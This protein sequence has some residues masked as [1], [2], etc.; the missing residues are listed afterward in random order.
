MILTAYALPEAQGDCPVCGWPLAPGSLVVS[1]V[2]DTRHLGCATPD[3]MAI[4]GC[5]HCGERHP[6]PYDGAC[7]L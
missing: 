5:P 6:Q 2:L 3:L 7:L 1:S 4:T